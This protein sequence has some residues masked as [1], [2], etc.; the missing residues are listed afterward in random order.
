MRRFSAAI[1]H[2]YVRL[3]RFRNGFYVPDIFA[4]LL[5]GAVGG[6]IAAASAVEDGHARPGFPISVSQVD[7]VLA[8][9]KGGIVGQVKEFIA[10]EQFVDEG[11][12]EARSRRWKR[13]R[14][15]WHRGRF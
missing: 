2:L 7:S 1:L 15:R 8:G 4:V 10:V 3:F 9:N 13:P 5:D 12:E 14:W 6:E 11:A